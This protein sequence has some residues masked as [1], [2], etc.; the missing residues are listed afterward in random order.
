MYKSI[1]SIVLVL[2]IAI[3]C[4]V[5][6]YA[7]ESL[8]TSDT[9]FDSENDKISQTDSSLND[10]QLTSEQIDDQQE[11]SHKQIPTILTVD[12]ENIYEGM[13]TSYENGYIPKCEDETIHIVLPLR[14]NAELCENRIVVALDLVTGASSPFEVGN[15]I[16]AFELRKTT[17]KN[18]NDPIELFLVE[19]SI[20][21]SS[22]RINGIYPVQFGVFGYDKAGHGV[23]FKYTLYVS[24]QD[25]EPSTH[26]PSLAD[27]QTAKPI[28]YINN[29]EASSEKIMAGDTFTLTVK[30]KSS[31][32]T[33]DI[34]NLLVKVDTGNLSIALLND[35][36]FV[37]VEKMEAGGEVALSLQFATEQSLPTGK[38]SL[39]LTFYYDADEALNLVS[40]DTVVV[41]I[42]QRTNMNLVMPQFADSV[43]VGETVPMQLQV[44]NMGR[45]Q[46]YNVRCAV[47]GSGLVPI[48]TGYIG[49]MA[50]GF[51]ATTIIELYIMALNTNVGD[52]DDN[53]YGDTIGTI[54]LTYEDESGTEYSDE[55][56]FKTNVKRPIVALTQTDS[57]DKEK[58]ETASQWWISVLSLGLIMAVLGIALFVGK[59]RKKRRACM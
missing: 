54:T 4:C 46:V 26:K 43:I 28:L 52:E 35:G 48:N 30:L 5:K 15:Y 27:I 45:D 59:L 9:A 16:K 1:I 19:F 25:G 12:T 49:T 36:N 55:I 38:Y 56:Q 57:V 11:V 29:S 18:G 33:S 22:D 13:D 7:V 31:I 20:K 24:I 2:C 51:S 8:A 3:S 50:A 40:T 32:V 23:E 17:P 53:L 41:D 37:R 58:E 10:S 34:H 21:L 39:N 47:S 44:I 14:S 6:A 42:Y